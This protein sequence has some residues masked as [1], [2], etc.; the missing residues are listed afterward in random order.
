M[1]Q[2]FHTVCFN[3]ENLAGIAK[4]LLTGWFWQVEA[5]TA[6]RLTQLGQCREQNAQLR[7]VLDKPLRL[8]MLIEPFEH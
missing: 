2:S 3:F 7:D 1:A 4:R 5:N 6:G 8:S